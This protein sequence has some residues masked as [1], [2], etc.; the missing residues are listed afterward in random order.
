LLLAIFV[1]SWNWLYTY[2]EDGNKFWGVCVVGVINIV[3]TIIAPLW[4][5][6]AIPFAL[7]F[8]IYGIVNAAN[9]NDDWYANY[10]SNDV[11]MR[12]A[13]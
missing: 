12:R 11:V 4:A 2:R 13:A 7:G 9:R 6:V 8:Y 1:G 3:L 5:V 10:N